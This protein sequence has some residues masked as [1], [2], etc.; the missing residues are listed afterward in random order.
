VNIEKKTV[1]GK[2]AAPGGGDIVMAA[3][4]QPAGRAPGAAASNLV[5]AESRSRI[6]TDPLAREGAFF[7]QNIV[8]LP[9]GKGLAKGG[10]DFWIGHRFPQKVFEKDSPANLFGF[11][12]AA[13]VAFGVRAGITD[14]LSVG[15]SRS[16]FFRT[17]E[18]N[19]N[20]Q[21]SRQADGMPF[22]LAVRG[23]VEGRNNFV[24]HGD[25]I[26]W[27]GYGPSLQ[28]IAVRS[29]AERVS[30]AAVP[31]FAFN[32]RN[33]NTP[34]T[35]QQFESDHD[36]TI[37]MGVGLGIRVLPTMSLVGEW[38]PRVWGYQGER[39]NRPQIGFGL[40][41]ATYRHTFSLTFSTVRPMTVSRYAQGTGGGAFSGQFDTFG[42]G[43]NI[44][45]RLR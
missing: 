35:F 18:F 37:A 12:S 23:S 44:Y 24:R 11:D 43:F 16:N 26:P 39:T 9:N 27:V 32:T 41:K 40:Q 31:T 22:S 36:N 42:I 20:L 14:R 17:I 3:P 8:D 21:V 34:S 29:F 6:P 19:S 30:F 28:V 33:E 7:G 38:V 45:R 1:D 5:Q 4:A 10:V 13:I 2:P 25:V 15:M